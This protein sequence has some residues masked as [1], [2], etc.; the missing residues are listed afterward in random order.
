MN[1]AFNVQSLTPTWTPGSM[2]SPFFAKLL[3]ASRSN[4]NFI[5]PRKRSALM[6]STDVESTSARAP[7]SSETRPSGIPKSGFGFSDSG[8]A[9][10]VEGEWFGYECSFSVCN[11]E[12]RNIPVRSSDYTKSSLLLSLPR[13]LTRQELVI[14]SPFQTHFGN[15]PGPLR[16]RRIS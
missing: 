3:V 4:A 12:A 13:L 14:P 9:S 10:S 8:F 2:V 1:L 15:V 11:G 16:P 6:K 7:A 5:A